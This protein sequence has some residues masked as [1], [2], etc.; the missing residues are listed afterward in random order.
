MV[1]SGKSTLTMFRGI[2]FLIQKNSPRIDALDKRL[3]TKMRHKLTNQSHSHR[4]CDK[5]MH[6]NKDL[7]KIS[8]K[9][10]AW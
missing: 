1:I 5:L 6:R 2:N 4:I 8:H 9:T 10:E 3:V 7:L